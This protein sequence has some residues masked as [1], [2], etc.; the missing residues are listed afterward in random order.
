[1]SSIEREVCQHIADAIGVGIEEVTP[2]T[3]L[4]SL[5]IGLEEKIE[6]MDN[7][8]IDYGID[9]ADDDIIEGWTTVQDFINYTNLMDLDL[10]EDED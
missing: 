9:P 4:A 6:I 3:T 10:E 2:S 7:I 5:D 8:S 1:M